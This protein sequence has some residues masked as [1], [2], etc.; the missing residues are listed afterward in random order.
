MA[1]TKILITGGAGYI[2]SVLINEL[3]KE[4]NNKITVVDKLIFEKNSLKS[5]I[6]SKKINFLNYDVR[7]YNKMKDLFVK[8]DI[9]I[10][11]AALVGAPLCEKFKKE[12][13]EI[14]QDAIKFLV[15]NSS[16]QQKIIFPVTNSGYGIG[17]A[18]KSCDENSPLNPISLY[19]KTKVQA[20]KFIL[21]KENTICYRLATVFGVSPRMR[22]DL[23]VNNF[24]LIA[25]KKKYLKLY[26]PHF[27]RNY[28]HINDVVEAII[29]AI[30]NFEILK[31]ETY[32]LGLSEANLT[33]ENLCKEI[34]KVIKDF[35][36]EIGY[37]QEDQDKRDYF[38]SNQKIEKKGFKALRSLSSG[39][40]EL[41]DFYNQNGSVLED[42]ISKIKL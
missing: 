3:V 37:D 15:E 17:E 34:Q 8:N 24:V 18:N 42:N 9:V 29:F 30:N 23:L 28:I 6:D 14:N 13:V 11:L 38:V 12:A 1:F 39:I 16:K 27:R 5:L 26:E 41:V 33:K 7:D 25:L 31:N 2:G 32:N 20:E 10:P 4:V 35:I 21:S 36:Y 19:G 40:E 22:I